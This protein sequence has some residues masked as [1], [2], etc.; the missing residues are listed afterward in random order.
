MVVASH[1]VRDAR[2]ARALTERVL[3]AWAARGL[4]VRYQGTYWWV[5][6]EDLEFLG[7]G[8]SNVAKLHG[9]WSVAVVA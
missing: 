8:W 1:R 7:L 4:W 6:E 9:W 3:R 2:Q 5:A